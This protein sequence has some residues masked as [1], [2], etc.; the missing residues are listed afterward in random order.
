MRIFSRP[1]FSATL[2]TG[3]LTLA[4]PATLAQL[5]PPSA[6][7][8]GQVRASIRRVA[9]RTGILVDPLV[10]K[11]LT[12]NALIF[13]G[14]FCYDPQPGERGNCPATLGTPPVLDQ[15][16]TA[17][18]TEMVQRRPAEIETLASRLAKAVGDDISR[19][20][21]PSTEPNEVGVVIVPATLRNSPIA[22][23]GAS[24]PTAL[25]SG[26]HYLLVRPGRHTLIFGSG[27]SLT[28]QTVA[29]S[30]LGRVALQGYPSAASAVLSSTA[31]GRVDAPNLNCRDE[32]QPQYSGPLAFF[33]WGRASYAENEA[34][35][36]SNLTPFA[37]QPAVEIRVTEETAGT[38]N[39][40]CLT[41]LSIA[42]A[43]A[44]AV[45]RGGC[46]RCG[47][48]ML[49]VIKIGRNVWL[50]IRAA[51]RL[52][53][54]AAGRISN[55][56]LDL[57]RPL[58][59]EIQRTFAGQ[60]GA[61]TVSYDQVDNDSA[62][63]TQV[64]SS[65]SL[66]TPWFAPLQAA[67]CRPGN[68]S[69][70]PL[71]PTLALKNNGTSCGAAEDFI[72]CGLPGGGIELTLAGSR[73]AIPLPDGSRTALGA[74]NGEEIRLS[75]VLV[76]EVGHWFGVPHSEAAGPAA[77]LDVMSQTY[78]SHR[79]CL[80]GA[81]KIMLN[82]AADKRWTYAARNVMGLRRGSAAR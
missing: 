28:R 62:L 42:F 41:G 82:N 13:S 30:A 10:A 81:S 77:Y 29:I 6:Q 79:T 20:G 18:L 61:A 78:D 27:A 53:A 32:P 80:S 59:S 73:Y 23:Q 34:V 54:L 7:V 50:D 24:G 38:C 40:S 21:W 44:I 9:N 17:Y 49:A 8:E 15:I 60:R 52:R 26:A 11:A 5:S 35:R 51:D 33:N 72:A 46:E 12:Q 19:A 22:L 57:S 58:A 55:T 37:S 31:I 43:R 36:R 45:W 76:H 66:P 75:S 16:V 2:L 63:T 39:R 1:R 14:N 3:F 47:G 71:R 65:D 64:C 69:F 70:G 25:G 68:A 56:D 48:N 67:L 4:S 74:S